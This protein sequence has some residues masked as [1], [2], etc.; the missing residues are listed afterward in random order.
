MRNMQTLQAKSIC[1]EKWSL[2]KCVLHMAT[3]KF[4]TFTTF[5]QWKRYETTN[6]TTI[7]QP[8]GFVC[9]YLGEPVPER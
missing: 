8:P 4:T 7:L 2:S 3:Y 1:I 9:D 5:T 6:A